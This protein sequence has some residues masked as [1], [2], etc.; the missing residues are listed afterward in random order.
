M[1]NAQLQECAIL[2]MDSSKKKTFIAILIFARKKYVYNYYQRVKSPFSSSIIIT[3]EYLLLFS[4]TVN[5]SK[6][7]FFFQFETVN[8]KELMQHAIILFSFC[9]NFDF[10]VF[11][12][13]F[14]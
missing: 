2:I 11:R 12:N 1:Q 3:H 5:S 10:N 14:I 6:A 9:N 4:E 8:Q 13:L 7:D